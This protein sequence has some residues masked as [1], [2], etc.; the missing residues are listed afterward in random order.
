MAGKVNDGFKDRF[1]RHRAKHREK[2]NANARER[3]RKKR[4]E[5]PELVPIWNEKVQKWRDD[6]PEKA[7]ESD[8]IGCS[9]YREANAE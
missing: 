1:A 3:A 4:I 6:N 9:K 8:R 5:H 7:K 2:I